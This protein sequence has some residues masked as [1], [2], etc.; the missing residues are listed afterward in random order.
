MSAWFVVI[1]CL[2]SAFVGAVAG[3][4][5]AEWLRVRRAKRRSSWTSD[6]IERGV[7]VFDRRAKERARK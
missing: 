3:C 1:A 5:G 7:Y 4:L 2:A 6:P